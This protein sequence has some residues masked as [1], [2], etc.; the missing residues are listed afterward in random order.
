LGYHF[1]MRQNRLHCV[2]YLR[3]CDFIRHFRDDVYLTLRLQLWVLEK[4][5]LACPEMDWENIIPGTLTMHITSLH[6]FQTDRIALK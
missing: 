2:Y 4:C 1:I 5:R 6:C 3:S